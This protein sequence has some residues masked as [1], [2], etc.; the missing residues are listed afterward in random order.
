MNSWKI[1]LLAALSFS[2]LW[3]LSPSRSA[4]KSEPGVVE[5]AYMGPGGPIA[6]PMDDAVRE[7]ERVSREAHKLDPSKPVYRVISGQNATRDPS[8]D[9]TR[10]LVSVAGGMPPDVIS[11]DRYA[12]SEWSARGTFTNLDPYLAKDIANHHPD[13]IHREDFYKPAWD[14]AIYTDPLSGHSGLYGMPYNL[15]NRVLFYNK[16]LLKRA[17]FVD[18]QGEGRPPKT[19]EELQAMAIKLTEAGENGRPAR[20]G[21]VPNFGNTFLY[22]YGWMNGGEFMSKDGKTCTLND[23]KIVGA[24]KWMTQVYDSLGGAKDVLAFQSTFQGGDLD[25]FILGKVAMKIDGVWMLDGMAQFA[26]NVNWGAAPPPLPAAEIAA[27][28][29]SLTWMGGWC[30]AIPSTAK[31]KDAAWE[32]IRFLSTFRANQ[33][34]A[35]SQRLTAL[36]QGRSFVPVQ[37]PNIKINDWLAKKYVYDDPAS[38]PKIKQAM[39]VFNGMIPA[40]RYRPVTMIGQLLWNQQIDAMEDAIFHKLSPQDALDRATMIVQRQLDAALHPPTN[41]AIQWSWLLIPYLAG[42]F[43]LALGVYFWDTRA[44]LRAWAAR[45]LAPIGG[46]KLIKVGGD[47]D[48]IYSSFLRSQ[49]KQGWFLASPWFFGMIV[50]TGGPIFFSIIISFTKYDILNPAHFVGLSN[51]IWMFTQDPL[52]WKSLWNTIYML[53]GVPLG[54]AVSLAIALLLNLKIK[55]MPVW[56]TFFYLPSIIPAVAS[57]ILWIWI[58]NPSSGLLNTALASVGLTGPNWLQDEHTSKI[59]LILMGL[60]GAGGGMILWLAGLKGISESYYEAASL[61]GADTIQKFWHVTLPMLSPYIF[62]NFIMGIIGTFQIFSQAFIMTK[63]GPVNST[64]FYSLH[65][66]NNA[67]RFLDMGYASAM[68]WVLFLI[69]FSLTL[70]QLRL[71]KRWVHYE[72]D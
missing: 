35:E 6:A 20:M 60:W 19:W 29:K 8:E 10:F 37:H 2:A 7:F 58:L 51:Y 33:L 50:F 56:R 36:S 63:G 28:K 68:A 53:A 25:P 16:D 13:A 24:L 18:A 1:A 71:Q 57:S 66:F 15:D 61:D 70:V 22:M 64:L 5:I 59:S 54:M 55:A 40:S 3:L 27:G 34:M 38:D 72:G 46:Q 39:Q 65:L 11:F 52:F 12:V 48:G 4:Q 69:V 31:N 26:K 49:W 44:G 47:V 32:L 14:E 62:F 45:L 41:V 67:F 23:P 42:I 17:G 21:F 43:L 9:P 30:Y